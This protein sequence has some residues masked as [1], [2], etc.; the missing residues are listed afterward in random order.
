MS[1]HNS[2]PPIELIHYPERNQSL[3]P[4]PSSSPAP[5]STPCL[6]PRRTR[7]PS[8]PTGFCRSC[9]VHCVTTRSSPMLRGQALR[10]VI[11]STSA[12]AMMLVSAV[13]LSSS[14]LIG[15]G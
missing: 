7:S 5:A 12:P 14:V 15:G 2:Q 10:L 11:V 9:S 1:T 4:E 8:H 13:F 6:L 3:W